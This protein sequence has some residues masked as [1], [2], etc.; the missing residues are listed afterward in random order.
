MT[1]NNLG[2]KWFISTYNCKE[3]NL[4][5]E[6]KV[7]IW[8]KNL[9]QKQWRASYSLDL[10]VFILHTPGSPGVQ[11]YTIHRGWP[12][13]YQSLI[14]KMSQVL[15][16]GQTYRDIFSI[17]VLFSDM[18]RSVSNR[19]KKK[20]KQHEQ[21]YSESNKFV[22]IL[23]DQNL[24][25]EILKLIGRHT[26]WI[27]SDTW[28]LFLKNTIICCF[29]NNDNPLFFCKTQVLIFWFTIYIM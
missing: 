18:S 25:L 8:K 23:C 26:F 5:H 6:L 27:L 20:R 29:K 3:E 16:I 12:L 14:M 4:G 28:Y 17:V 24:V 2:R 15:L 1:K 22:R 9:K 19:L 11:E 21:V 7:E 10:H 13:A